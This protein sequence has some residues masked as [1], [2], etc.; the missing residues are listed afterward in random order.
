MDKQT[1]TVKIIGKNAIEKLESLGRKKGEY[2]T[3]LIE[4]DIRFENIE[5]RIEQLEKKK[6]K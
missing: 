1:F 2:L 4:Q 3:R 6:C 5:R